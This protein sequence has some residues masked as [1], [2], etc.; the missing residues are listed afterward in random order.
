MTPDESYEDEAPPRRDEGILGEPVIDGAWPDAL[1]R[2]IGGLC[3]F[4]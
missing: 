3:D 2:P 1:E 4:D